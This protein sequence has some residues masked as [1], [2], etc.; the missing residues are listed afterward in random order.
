MAVFN[1]A[2]PVFGAN[3]NNPAIARQLQDYLFR[4]HEQLTYVLNNI[5]TENMDDATKTTIDDAS[6]KAEQVATALPKEVD[7]LHRDIVQN[8]AD[9]TN[10]YTASIENNNKRLETVFNETY[11]A[12]TET[13]ALQTDMMS[14]F[15]QTAQDIEITFKE[16]NDYA[17]S[18]DG[19]LS[20][21]M[22]EV[23]TNIRF[24]IDGIELGKLGS[25]FSTLLGNTKLS[26]LQNGVEIAY[27]SNNKMYITT[28]EIQDKLI[29]GNE[30]KGFFEWR[31]ESN[32]SLSLVR[33][34]D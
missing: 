9:I 17:V 3:I 22:N 6:A 7:Q 24:S 31:L 29:I 4:V 8:A 33:R 16:T 10:A 15:E 32:G 21:F 18:V 26:F 13:A 2:P 23:A 20:E 28:A 1:T 14:R 11:T 27:I 30:N 34:K 12:K 5:S 19:K 25:M